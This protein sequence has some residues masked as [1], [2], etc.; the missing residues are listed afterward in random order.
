MIMCFC[1]DARCLTLLAVG[2]DCN[3]KMSANLM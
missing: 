2:T 1:I 3:E